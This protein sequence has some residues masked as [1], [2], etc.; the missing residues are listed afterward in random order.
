MYSITLSNTIILVILLPPQERSQLGTTH[1]LGKCGS[2][3]GV[4]WFVS[5]VCTSV[6]NPGQVS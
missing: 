2:G 1:V 5:S 6:T 3:G 4:L